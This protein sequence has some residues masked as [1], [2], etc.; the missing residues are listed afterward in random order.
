[1]TYRKS[2]FSGCDGYKFIRKALK[3]AEI[4]ANKTLKNISWLWT[5]LGVDRFIDPRDGVE[6]LSLSILSPLWRNIAEWVGLLKL[7][8]EEMRKTGKRLKQRFMLSLLTLVL[9]RRHRRSSRLQ[10]RAVGECE[11]ASL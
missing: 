10:S 7:K 8:G 2:A 1:M 3:P 11:A 6:I 4:G 9:E 5:A